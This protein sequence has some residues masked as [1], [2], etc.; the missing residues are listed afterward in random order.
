MDLTH[1]TIILF[2]ILILKFDRDKIGS[3]F[4]YYFHISLDYAGICRYF[5]FNLLVPRWSIGIN[6]QWKNSSYLPLRRN[7]YSKSQHTSHLKYLSLIP[8]SEQKIPLFLYLFILYLFICR[9]SSKSL[10]H[11]LKTSLHIDTYDTIFFRYFLF[12]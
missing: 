4:Y 10:F 3:F 2:T 6:L 9:V 8:I 11:V 12:R 5:Q 7:I 1:C